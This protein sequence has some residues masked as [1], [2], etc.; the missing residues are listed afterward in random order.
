LLSTGEVY[1]DIA[2]LEGIGGIEKLLADVPLERVLFGSHSPSF[3]FEAAQLKL[4]ES[5]LSAAQRSAIT[6]ENAWRLLPLA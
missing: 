4:Q 2:M 6:Q 3:Y 5:Q 1:V